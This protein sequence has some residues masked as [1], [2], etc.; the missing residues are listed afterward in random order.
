[1]TV[2]KKSKSVFLSVGVCLNKNDK[3]FNISFTHFLQYHFVPLDDTIVPL[4]IDVETRYEHFSFIILHLL[5]IYLMKFLKI[6]CTYVLNIF[7][8]SLTSFLQEKT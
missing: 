3:N 5:F 4:T 2:K 8:V 1:M 6:P 7:S